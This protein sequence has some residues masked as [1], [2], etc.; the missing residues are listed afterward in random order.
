MEVGEAAGLKWLQ[1]GEVIRYM[2]YPFRLHIKQREKNGKMLSQI[3][4]HIIRWSN[5]QLSLVGQIMVA[6]QV[7]FSSIWYLA[8]CTNILGK[9]LKLARATIRNYIW[10]DRRD[11]GTRARV[12]WDTTILP[13]VRGGIKI[14]DPP[15]ANL[16]LTCKTADLRTF[17]GIRALEV[18]CKILGGPKTTI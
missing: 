1:P 9:A 14:L 7:V 8:S 18:T 17:G 4:K 12:K 16:G 3:R 5:Q 2:D 10:S 11:A 6:N 15:M 13:I